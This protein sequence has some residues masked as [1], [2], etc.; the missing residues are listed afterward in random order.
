M[1]ILEVASDPSEALA[2]ASRRKRRVGLLSSLASATASRRCFEMEQLRSHTT[3]IARKDKRPGSQELNASPLKRIK[4]AESPACTQPAPPFASHPRPPAQS[5][6][7]V[8]PQVD[9]AKLRG[10]GIGGGITEN[11]PEPEPKIN[12]QDRVTFEIR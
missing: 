6:K 5:L 9:T 11:E 1:H 8:P 2:G 12:A 3:R 10:H 7:D 4:H